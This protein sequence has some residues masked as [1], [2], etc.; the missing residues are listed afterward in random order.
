M[1][2]GTAVDNQYVC[3]LLNPRCWN[4]WCKCTLTKPLRHSVLSYC[5]GFTA[6]DEEVCFL[7]DLLYISSISENGFLV[8]AVH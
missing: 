6:P 5:C 7:S 4:W 3:P 2:V 8:F 1:V